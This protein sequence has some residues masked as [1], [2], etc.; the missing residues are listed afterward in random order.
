[1]PMI[2]ASLGVFAL[3]LAGAQLAF[4]SGW[5][6]P[7]LAPTLALALSAVGS[8]AADAFLERR[9]RSALQAALGRLLPPP[10]PRAF[11]ISY[12]RE[13]SAWPARMLRDE[14][15]KR[16]GTSSVFLDTTSLRA[17][18]EWP[19]RI[20]D[21]LRSC[22]V[23]LVLISPSWLVRDS[24]DGAPRIHDPRDWVRREIETVLRRP[25]AIVVPVL[26]DDAAMPGSGDLPESL[27][28]LADQQAVALNANSLAAD[29]DA[30]IESIEAGRIHDH[31]ASVASGTASE[32]LRDGHEPRRRFAPAQGER[33]RTGESA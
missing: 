24:A 27:R 28:A 6:V 10:S 9:R 1:L 12:R 30:L 15:V 32:P 31:A 17:G 25:D 13:E 19:Q 22:S 8:T 29:L 11:F 21:A 14:L 5:I 16:F 33:S 23:M 7:V 3:L 26:L 4:E 2:L 20:Q 18:Q